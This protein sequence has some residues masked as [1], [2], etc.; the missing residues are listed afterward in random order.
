[1]KT[2]KRNEDQVALAQQPIEQE[3]PE[4]EFDYKE[5][6]R[7]YKKLEHRATTEHEAICRTVFLQG[8]LLKEVIDSE[9]RYGKALVATFAQDCGVRDIKRLYKAHA[10]ARELSYDTDAFEQYI[11]AQKKLEKRISVSGMEKEL[12]IA[13]VKPEPVAMLPSYGGIQVSGGATPA[14]AVVNTQVKD[15]DV[16]KRK[17]IAE[18]SHEMQF[19]PS[20]GQSVPLP[21]QAPV[22]SLKEALAT[23]LAL[24]TLR[25][26]TLRQAGEVLLQIRGV[27][28]EALA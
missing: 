27:A 15:K 23:I 18:E 16:R 2:S 20:P 19:V 26:D 10:I 5:K 3:L 7:I 28:T 14:R 12:A 11:A 13:K 9:A 1:M 25:I 8:C 17:E 22:P 24:T 21:M 4:L 6:V